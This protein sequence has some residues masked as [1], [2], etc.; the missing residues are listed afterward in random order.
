M[1]ARAFAELV[2]YIESSVEGA[3]FIFKLS[4]LHGLFEDR[5]SKLGVGKSINK[6]RL[7][8]QLLEQFHGEC[9]E[10]HDGKNV[11]LVFNEGL[12][13]I[14]KESTSNRNLESEAI[15]MA[16]LVKVIR[17]E[18]FNWNPFN[19]SGSFPPNCQALSVPTTLKTLVSMLL[20]GPNVQN[21]DVSESQVCLTL[22]QLIHFNVKSKRKPSETNRHFKH[23]ETPLPLY[24][25]LS[26]H[27]LTR[28]KKIINNLH[29]LGISVSYSRVI[30]LENSLTN[31]LCKQFEEED[32]VCPAQLRKG[33]FTVGALDNID[34]NLSSTTAQGSFHGTGISIF[35]FPTTINSGISRDPVVIR[36]N[37][38]S[39]EYTLPENYTN[40][41]AVTCKINELALPEVRLTTS[42]GHLE[43]AKIVELNWI[44][45]ALQFSYE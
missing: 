23:R 44:E 19:F 20:N 30:E 9:Q 26:I 35:Q 39:T 22:S 32:V 40:N 36:S 38:N 34:H 11:L 21:Q 16:K 8:N 45:H 42:S 13:K 7:K 4:E 10:Q 1:L 3:N 28:S 43:R 14:L 37:S 12:K 25:G 29:R 41:P 5:L 24:V 15:S 18:I 2:C 17:Q 27:T 33:L 31:A 6:T